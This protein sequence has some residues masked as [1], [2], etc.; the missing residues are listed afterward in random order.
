MRIWFSLIFLIMLGRTVLVAQNGVSLFG[1]LHQPHGSG[2]SALWGYTAPDGR[3]YAIIGASTGTAFIDITDSANVHE[4]DFVSGPNSSWREMRTWANFAY[5]VSEGGGGT[6]IIDLSYL[7]DSVHLVTSFTYTSGVNNTSRSHSIEIFDGYM[8][9][10]GCANWSPG[11]IVI[12]NLVRPTQPRFESAYTQRYIHDCYVR[13]DTIFGAAINSSG[14]VDIIDVRV[15]TNPTVIS[16]I[17]YAGSGTHNAWTTKDRRYVISTD[18]IGSTPKNLKFWNLSTLPSPPPSPSATY[19]I[20]P[21]DI[22]HN[23]TVRGNYAYVAWYTAGLVVVNITNPLSPTTAGSY[24]TYPGP[25]P[26]YAGAWA[27]YPYFPSGKIAISDMQ[28][29]TWLFRFNA[30]LPRRPVDLLAPVHGD[31]IR[32]LDPITFRWTSAANLQADPHYYI[33]SSTGPGVFLYNRV[34]DTTFQITNTSIL[35]PGGTYTWSVIT[36]DE[37]NTTAST[38]T[39]QFVFDPPLAQIAT[40]TDTLDFGQVFVDSTE[41]Q[42]LQITNAGTAALVI[43]SMRTT[44]SVFATDFAGPV[45]VQP[46][47]S[48]MTMVSFTPIANSAYDA[49]LQIFSNAFSMPQED[50]SLLGI[51]NTPTAVDDQAG[52]PRAYTLEQNYPNPFNPSTTIT[53]VLLKP[54]TV[55]LKVYNVL[56]E[57][58]ASLLEDN[59]A[60]G[61]HTVSFDAS[62]LA[63]GLYFYKLSTAEFTDVKKMILMK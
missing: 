59:Q 27:V 1:H 45:S 62:G 63:S 17:T 49:A 26:D 56:G 36:K 16:R 8:Y 29:G 13:N 47:S 33:F 25:S 5:V 42:P 61:T 15:K 41:A 19:S 39:F 58:I 24:D 54:G 22:V 57:E 35:Q 10:N 9:L 3:E 18:E 21:T 34:D 43:D 37:V 2:Y 11:G 31:T 14:G 23:V 20:S 4:V 6:Q 32:S 55:S 53:Y 51:G 50:V 52:P 48:Y 60:A 12:F 44:N 46:E 7:P 30:L 28:T 38:D 40:N